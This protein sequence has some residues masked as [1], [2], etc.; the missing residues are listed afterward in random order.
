MLRAVRRYRPVAHTKAKLAAVNAVS[1]RVIGAELV[2][3]PLVQQLRTCNAVAIAPTY[4]AHGHGV[5]VVAGWARK[6]QA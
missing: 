6:P 5:L 2:L 1:H 4:R 3:L